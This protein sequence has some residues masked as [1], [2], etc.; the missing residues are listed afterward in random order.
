MVIH[1]PS[2]EAMWSQKRLESQTTSSGKATLEPYDNGNP[3]LESHITHLHDFTHKI[4]GLIT[5][6]EGRRR[7]PELES[8]PSSNPSTGRN[9]PNQNG[10][11]AIQIQSIIFNTLNTQTGPL[12]GWQAEVLV[13]ERIGLIFNM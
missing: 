4:L 7:A 3:T 10:P 12:S 2:E 13:H 9:I 8:A 1:N 5:Q 11:A 6:Q